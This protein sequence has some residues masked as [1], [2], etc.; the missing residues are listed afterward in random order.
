MSCFSALN[1]GSDTYISLPRS[2][3]FNPKISDTL[4]HVLFKKTT[5]TRDVCR[6]SG[7]LYVPFKRFW[8]GRRESLVYVSAALLSLS[9]LKASHVPRHVCPTSSTKT[10]MSAALLSSPVC[11]SNAAHGAPCA[12]SSASKHRSDYYLSLL[13]LHLSWISVSSKP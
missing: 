4:M 2:S 12:C 10:R 11:N 9:N 7:F 5:G 6:A 3:F 13:R 8:S 1:H